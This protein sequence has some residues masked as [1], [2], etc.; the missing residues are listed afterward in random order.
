MLV[1]EVGGRFFRPNRMAI[2]IN[3]P[4]YIMNV[5]LYQFYEVIMIWSYFDQNSKTIHFMSYNCINVFVGGYIE[6]NEINANS[7]RN[8][9]VAS[10]S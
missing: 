6:L 10:S 7:T 9:Q 5:I 4:R 1:L 3:V 8:S 2:Q